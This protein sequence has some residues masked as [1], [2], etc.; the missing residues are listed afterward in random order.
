MET[1]GVGLNAC[2]SWEGADQR[3]YTQY[4]PSILGKG[5]TTGTVTRS[6]LPEF[7]ARREARWGAGSV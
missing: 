4:D 5:K 2:Y 1:H 7:G 6:V 3:G